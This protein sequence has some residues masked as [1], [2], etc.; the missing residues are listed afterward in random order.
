[1][2][3]GDPVSNSGSYTYKVKEN[4]LSWRVEW[5]E[6]GENPLIEVEGIFPKATRVIISI[7]EDLFKS[8]YWRPEMKDYLDEEHTI[9]KIV[10][11]LK[12]D[13]FVVLKGVHQ[14]GRDYLWP[15]NNIKR[16]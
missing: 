10:K 8:S 9:L 3:P 16:I 7:G 6:L 5:L 13:C 14:E 4:D 1:M 11:D 12:G 15:L 2:G